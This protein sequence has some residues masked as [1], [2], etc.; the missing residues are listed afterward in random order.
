MLAGIVFQLGTSTFPGCDRMEHQLITNS[1]SLTAFSV[2][3]GEYLFRYFTGR[4]ARPLVLNNS[5]A[6][7]VGETS[8]FDRPPLDKALKH[9]LIGISFA[10]LLLYIR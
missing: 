6:E 5:S 9:L 7:T 4:P 10:T 3:G 1:V 8:P 2:L